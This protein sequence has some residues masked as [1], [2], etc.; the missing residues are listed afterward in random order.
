[1]GK[2][3]ILSEEVANRI[4]AGEVVERPASV[5]KECVE[6]AIDAGATEIIVKIVNGGKDFIQIIDNGSGMSEED[7][8]IAFER[9]ATSKISSADDITHIDTMGFRGEALPSIASVS[10]FQLIT[11]SDKDQTATEINFSGGRLDLVQQTAS[12]KGTTITVKNLFYN[13]PARRKFLKTEPV[14]YR[15]ILNYMHYQAVLFPNISFIFYNN[16]KE[17]FNYPITGDVEKRMLDIFGTTFTKQNLLFLQK[18]TAI[19]KINGYLQD[20]D[21]PTA[22]NLTKNDSFTPAQNSFFDVHYVFVNRRFI[23]DKTVY[24]AIKSAYEP[25]LKKYRFFESGKLPN[26][27]LI[28]DIDPEEIDVNVHPAKT[29]IRF[30]NPAAVYQF[31]KETIYDCLYDKEMNAYNDT[32][33]KLSSLPLSSPLSQREQFIAQ[34]I[35]NPVSEKP[36][37]PPAPLTTPVTPENQAKGISIKDIERSILPIQRSNQNFTQNHPSKPSAPVY[38]ATPAIEKG[39]QSIY[40]PHEQ[41]QRFAADQI[42]ILK[43]LKEEFIPPWQLH[44]TYILIQTDSGFVAIDQHAAHERI[45]Y[46]KLLK[47]IENKKPNKQKLLFP[48]VIDLPTFL[49]ESLMEVISQNI[50]TFSDLGFTVKT[51]SGNSIVLDDIPSEIEY[52]DG[53]NIFLDILQQ[54]QDELAHTKDFRIASAASV[55]CK[56]AIKAGKKLTKKEMIELVNE[57][58]TCEFPFQCPHGRPLIIK[59]SLTDIE[60]M[61]KRII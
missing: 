49:S 19:I 22:T 25:F 37:S 28:I 45:L 21:S 10:R 30:R 55:A 9:H 40:N 42:E 43:T 60:K 50:E 11:R 26:Y 51:F 24:S 33:N 59:I 1:M 12:N 38:T 39:W 56:A 41:N 6:N 29:E 44:Q 4:A 54:L 32:K 35:L 5:V 7:A 31:V 8:F 17:K 61:F 48:L 13:V 46:E 18:D 27:I 58:F 15:H 3:K 57:L 34:E 14:E 53:G 23:N 47:N 20:I 36:A 16:D 2:I 52:W